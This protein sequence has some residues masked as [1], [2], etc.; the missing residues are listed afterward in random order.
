MNM[1]IS[2][3]KNNYDGFITFSGHPVSATLNA[4]FVANLRKCLT[5]DSDHSDVHQLI[6]IE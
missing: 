3:V 2:K 1:N 5:Y 6:S 4:F